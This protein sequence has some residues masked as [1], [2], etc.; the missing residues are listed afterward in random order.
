MDKAGTLLSRT[1]HALS[2]PAQVPLSSNVVATENSEQL[3]TKELF[4]IVLWQLQ[5]RFRNAAT[6]H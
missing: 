2:V 6:L 1:A 3:P 5:L 4:Q